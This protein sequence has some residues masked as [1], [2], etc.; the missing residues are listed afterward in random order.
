MLEGVIWKKKNRITFNNKKK[1]NCSVCNK[2]LT[3]C[4]MKRHLKSKNCI[5]YK[6]KIKT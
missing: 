3:K 5:S 2:L 6:L 4:N 1:E